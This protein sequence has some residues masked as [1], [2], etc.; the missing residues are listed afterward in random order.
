MDDNDTVNERIPLVFPV[1]ETTP[2]PVQRSLR[3]TLIAI[4]AVA[5][6]CDFSLVTVVIP[7]I[8]DILNSHK[9]AVPSVLIGLLFA[10]KPAAQILTN[11]VVSRVVSA[12]GHFRLMLGALVILCASTVAF[13]VTLH[14]D[15]SDTWLF[16]GLLM[17]SRIVQGVSSSAVAVAGSALISR[18]HPQSLR[19]R[20]LS[21]SQL[22]IA[23]GAFTG[24]IVGGLLAG[25]I[26]YEVPFYVLAGV[27]AADLLAAVF[28]LRH[29]DKPVAPSTALAVVDIDRADV[30]TACGMTA[31]TWTDVTGSKAVTP[32]GEAGSSSD[33]LLHV[34]TRPSVVCFAAAM[35]LG[36]MVV[37]VV[38][39]TIPLFLRDQFDYAPQWQGLVFASCT[40]GYLLAVP[41]AGA[42]ADKFQKTPVVF[43]GHV[44][45]IAGAL[46]LAFFGTHLAAVLVSLV[47][48]GAGVGLATI[49][50]FP[51][52]TAFL[53]L[54]GVGDHAVGFAVADFSVSLALIVGPLAGSALY[55]AFSFR[56]LMIS[57]AC[58]IGAVGG[59]LNAALLWLE[60]RLLS[61]QEASGETADDAAPAKPAS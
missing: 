23:V 4:A 21:T 37:G 55:Q 18:H 6:F 52:M 8:P 47:V 60:R 14:A 53:D 25:L 59:F 42:A 33:S 15:P 54:Y 40:L 58:V 11:L 30:E 41:V 1:D 45:C 3:K 17:A 24:P 48:V 29:L 44:T 43:M 28:F 36:E 32:D 49:P 35:L 20:A 39:P 57:L 12:V 16:Y 34:V 5:N 10:S 46:V 19:G 7:I 50:L 31:V 51:L 56:T 27:V 13:A 22:G 2:A 38:E 9:R 61:N 26:G